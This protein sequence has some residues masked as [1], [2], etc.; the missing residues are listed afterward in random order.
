MHFIRRADEEAPPN[1]WY[2]PS[3]MQKT[4]AS[5]TRATRARTRSFFAT[6]AMRARKKG[7]EKKQCKKTSSLHLTRKAIWMSCHQ[8]PAFTMFVVKTVILS[9]K[10][11]WKHRVFSANTHS[12]TNKSHFA[13][14][15]VR[16]FSSLVLMKSVGNWEKMLRVYYCHKATI[17]DVALAFGWRHDHHITKMWRKTRKMASM[18]GT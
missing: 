3:K 1:H 5:K 7:K 10:L 6:N 15:I 12:C 9:I 11:L 2:A 16:F 17:Y 18:Y 4:N 14:K 8:L 13:P